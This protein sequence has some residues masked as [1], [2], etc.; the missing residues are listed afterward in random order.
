MDSNVLRLIR[1]YDPGSSI[2]TGI[3]PRHS[4]E[5]TRGIWN[6]VAPKAASPPQPFD[7]SSFLSRRSLTTTYE[8][9]IPPKQQPT[10]PRLQR[11]QAIYEI[12]SPRPPPVPPP[13][14]NSMRPILKYTSR[15]RS[16]FIV[17]PH[18]TEP[19]TIEIDPY[20]P[21]PLPPNESS[22]TYQPLI[23]TGTK[24]VCSALSKSEWDLRLQQ[25]QLPIRPPSVSPSPVVLNQQQEKE[26]Y[27]ASFGRSKSSTTINHN[28]NN[29][30]NDIDDFDEVS[31]PIVPSGS[32]VERLKQ[33]FVTKSSSDITSPSLNNADRNDSIDSNLN[34]RISNNQINRSPSIIKTTPPILNSIESQSPRIINKPTTIIQEVTPTF[35]KPILRSQKT[36]DRYAID[37]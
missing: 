35:K 18:Q 14:V 31:A 6:T 17:Q 15:S 23:T 5:K 22:A 36:I 8:D 10:T 2:T 20:I 19:L 32:C 7:S 28:N 3:I 16:E 11:Q 21:P 33:L 24:R 25:E 1:R 34:R 13:P 27:R 9:E 30:D 29:Q 37:R 4:L 26:S 12:E